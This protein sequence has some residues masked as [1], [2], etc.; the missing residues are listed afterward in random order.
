MARLS[1]SNGYE[2]NGVTGKN[3]SRVRRVLAKLRRHGMVIYRYGV[4]ADYTR[5]KLLDIA[6]NNNLTVTDVD[7]DGELI[8][9]DDAGRKK[10]TYGNK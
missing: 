1:R 7:G 5:G 10:F 2:T 3:D 8:I 4:N 6:L 9:I